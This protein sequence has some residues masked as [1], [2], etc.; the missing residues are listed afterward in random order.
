MLVASEPV[1]VSIKSDGVPAYTGTLEGQQSREFDASGKMTVLVGNAGG[2]AISVNG[3]QVAL[4]GAHGEVK[5]LE[6]TPKGAQVVPRT[7]PSPPTP[8]DRSALAGQ[9]ERPT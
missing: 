4:K 6:L 9:S 3:A 8:V 5:L 1:W 7:S 2:L